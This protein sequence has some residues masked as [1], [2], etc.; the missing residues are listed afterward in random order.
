MRRGL[1]RTLCVGLAGCGVLAALPALLGSAAVAA[2]E[3]VYT[4]GNY[5]VDAQAA[6]AVAAKEKALADGQQAAFRSLLKRI[7]PV[8]SYDRLNRLSALKS[9]DF[10]EGVSV[11]SERNSRTRY[12]ASL[13]F[14]FRSQ[15]VRAVLQQEGLPF[16]EDQA[17]E[18]I[19]VPVLRDGQGGVD[20]G[21]GQRAWSDTW[22]GLD[23]EH[24][25]TPVDVQDLK[26][27]IQP[28]TLN[29]L[30]QGSGEAGRAVAGAYGRP[31]VV[32]AFA[33]LDAAAKRL[34]ITFVGL[35]AVGPLYLK[36]SYRVPDGDTRYAME[37]AAVIGQ[38][39]LEGRW[40][41]VKVGAGAAARGMFI[42]LRA[43]YAGFGEWRE[44]R[45]RLLALPGVADL[46]VESESAQSASL[47]LRYPGSP[48]ELAS[49]LNAQGLA[50][51]SGAE[52]LV[53]RS[54]F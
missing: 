26:P 49:A 11:R 9:S 12:I 44:M 33:E 39:V 37:L 10:L 54:A 25:V 46:R 50:L 48:A 19:V 45:Q 34:N 14:Q 7:V 2:N 23:L 52:G 17:R 43:H 36:R 40:K 31:Q 27:D 42:S 30:L 4:V 5:P 53:L 3:D 13:D 29:S 28:D 21:A 8:L 35:D 16:V 51:D 15:S 41:A 1:R 6:N 22:K 38:G 24:S 20:K 32:F 18:I 47:T